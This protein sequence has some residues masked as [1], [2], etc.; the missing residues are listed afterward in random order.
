MLTS[1]SEVVALTNFNDGGTGLAGIPH[2]SPQQIL[3]D[4]EFG[5]SPSLC[6]RI[7]QGS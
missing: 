6:H 5:Y 2:R 7:L 4:P 3:D 1:V